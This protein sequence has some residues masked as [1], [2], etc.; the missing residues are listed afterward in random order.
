MSATVTVDWALWSKPEASHSDYHIIRASGASEDWPLFARLIRPLLPGSPHYAESTDKGGPGLPWVTFGT[1]LADDGAVASVNVCVTSK[2]AARDSS[3]RLLSRSL[4]YRFPSAAVAERRAGFTALWRSVRSVP[5]PDGAEPL[6]LALAPQPWDEIAAGMERDGRFDWYAAAAAALLESPVTITGGTGLGPDR[7]AAILDSIACLIPYGFRSALTAATCV[8]GMTDHRLRLVFAPHPERGAAEIPFAAGSS[9]APVELGELGARFLR[10]LHGLVKERHGSVRAV[11]RIMAGYADHHD[12]GPAATQSRW[13]LS[14]LRDRDPA[15][16]VLRDITDEH[17][18]LRRSP[19]GS[20]APDVSTAELR[21]EVE[22]VLRTSSAHA[23]ARWVLHEYLARGPF[24]QHLPQDQWPAVLSVVA[25]VT[26]EALAVPATDR[27]PT[28][29][30]DDP[31]RFGTR[32]AECFLA[33][34]PDELRDTLVS[35]LLRPLPPPRR[36]PL[37]YD[38]DTLLTNIAD[39]AADWIESAL[40]PAPVPDPAKDR[41]HS[42]LTRASLAAQPELVYRMLENTLADRA[43]TRRTLTLLDAPTSPDPGLRLLVRL[44][45]PKPN[46]DRPSPLD[47]VEEITAAIAA[48]DT[49]RPG[50]AELLLCAARPL[51]R[52]DAVMPA[53]WPILLSAATEQGTRPLVTRRIIGTARPMPKPDD[54]SDDNRCERYDGWLDTLLLLAGENAPER[55]SLSAR[56]GASGLDA[57]YLESLT[58]AWHDRSCEPWRDRLAALAIEHCINAHTAHTNTTDSAV[59]TGPTDEASSSR[60]PDDRTLTAV[61]QLLDLVDGDLPPQVVAV[62]IQ[63]RDADSLELDRLPEEFW[64]RLGDRHP[65]LT[66]SHWATLLR[67]AG[68]QGTAAPIADLWPKATAAGLKPYDLLTA[69]G[70]WPRTSTLRRFLT[71]LRLYLTGSVNQ[72]QTD[73]IEKL[74]ETVQ[75]PDS[76][77]PAETNDH[78]E[79][80]RTTLASGV[81]GKQAARAFRTASQHRTATH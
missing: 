8:D 24:P 48:T 67:A 68:D 16:S 49:A 19:S 75:L 54:P 36:P 55:L 39:R 66:D 21:N 34:C 35:L 50:W 77:S 71:D 74:I 63:A 20:L 72:T 29:P 46:E 79:E 2:T 17:G 65:S 9:P 53:V 15:A 52:V 70:P 5:L 69:L 78:R 4:L 12:F 25:T 18:V 47:R 62:L 45:F 61:G 57:G 81:W 38:R 64:I 51:G 56:L 31:W 42:R 26:G 43:R 13:A 3:A 80:L 1:E 37:A 10:E 7:A 23:E 59:A 76:F 60:G 6:R 58:T 73:R 14:V 30:E 41:V 22:Q 33:A 11:A 28:R 44:L 27:D 32:V 40:P